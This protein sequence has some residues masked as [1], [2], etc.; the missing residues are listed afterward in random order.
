MANVSLSAGLASS[1]SPRTKA[2]LEPDSTCP[3][4][5]RYRA[6]RKRIVSFAV[7]HY[8]EGCRAG[9]LRAQEWLG[10][11]HRG[12]PAAYGTLQYQVLSLA[13]F[14]GAASTESEVRFARGQI[15]G[16]CLAIELPEEAAAAAARWTWGAA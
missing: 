1:V 6:A 8:G 10:N 2:F 13:S 14:L 15:V 12:D 9:H 4:K 7:D 5:G 3:V 16:F 11:P